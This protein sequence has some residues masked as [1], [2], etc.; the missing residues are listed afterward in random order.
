MGRSV[1]H[2]DTRTL[3]FWLANRFTV[4]VTT[5]P[6]HLGVRR[7]TD[8]LQTGLTNLLKYSV[9]G[10]QFWSSPIFNCSIRLYLTTRRQELV[11][12]ILL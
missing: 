10:F 8:T 2:A 6:D 9:S 12:V 7:S 3:S 1:D 11:H 5:E 4:T